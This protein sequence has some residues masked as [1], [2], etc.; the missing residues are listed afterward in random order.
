MNRQTN[1]YTE[2]SKGRHIKGI[3]GLMLYEAYQLSNGRK[4]TYIHPC[5]KYPYVIIVLHVHYS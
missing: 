4:S 1:M 3:V 5:C 2:Y